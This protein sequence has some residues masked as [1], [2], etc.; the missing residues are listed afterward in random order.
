MLNEA[1]RH[2]AN[3]EAFAAL[4]IQVEV[5]WRWRQHGPPKRCYPIRIRHCVTTQRTSTWTYSLHN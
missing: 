1:S 5:F 4:L 3:F 2:D